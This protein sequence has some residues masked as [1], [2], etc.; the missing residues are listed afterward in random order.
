MTEQVDYGFFVL[1]CYTEEIYEKAK[2]LHHKAEELSQKYNRKIQ[3]ER[4]DASGTLDSASK[5]RAE[6]DM[7]FN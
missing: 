3:F 1:I 5:I 4:I 2:S 6:K 7:G